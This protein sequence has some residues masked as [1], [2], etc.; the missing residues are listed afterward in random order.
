MAAGVQA[1]LMKLFPVSF[2]DQ[3]GPFDGD[4][5]KDVTSPLEIL[6]ALCSGRKIGEEANLHYG[7]LTLLWDRSPRCQRHCSLCPCRSRYSP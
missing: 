7:V 5:L 2:R 6:S 4:K 3:A 1:G